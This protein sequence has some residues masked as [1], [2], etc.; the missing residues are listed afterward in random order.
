MSTRSRGSAHEGTGHFIAQ[1]FTA[2]GLL[3]L[4]PWFIVAAALSLRR[5]GYTAVI[6]FLSHPVNAVGIILL[7]ALGLYHMRLGMA[8]VVLDYI[9]KPLTKVLLLAL[10]TLVVIAL[11]AGA[12]YALLSINFGV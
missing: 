9:A 4:G 2:L 7:L 10:N 12:A 5:G 11:A 8:E 1:R 3:I 6:D